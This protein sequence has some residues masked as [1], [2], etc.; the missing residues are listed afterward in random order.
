MDRADRESSWGDDMSRRARRKEETLRRIEEVGWGL[1]TTQGYEATSTREIADAADIAAGTLFNYFPE[2]R[3]LLIHLM[4]RQIDDAANSAFET[5][6]ASSLEE[7]LT[8]VFSA[9]TRCYARERRLSRVFIKELL[10]TDGSQRADTTAW[11]FGLVS[12][13]A[14]LIGQA[15]RRGELDSSVD[16]MDA[17]QQVFSMHYFGMVTWLGGTIP[18]R[19]AQEK[20]FQTALSL[21]FRGIRRT[22]A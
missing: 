10:F 5:M 12:R 9:L 8:Y 22:A 3:S 15:K 20:Q 18:S 7:Q 17:A 19:T 13:V 6:E 11:T 1:F 16:A 2:K 21:L 14:G 4:Q